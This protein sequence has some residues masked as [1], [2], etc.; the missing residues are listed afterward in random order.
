MK[1]F[2]LIPYCVLVINITYLRAQS[3]SSVRYDT[4]DG[5]PSST[6]YDVSQDKNGFIWFATENGL[7]RFDG[8][9]FK[10]FTTK[11]GLPDNSIL[12]VHGDNSGR[13]Y[14][15]PFTHSLYYYQDDKFFHVPIPEKYKVDL[16]TISLFLNK[17]DKIILS[18]ITD[19]YLLENGSFISFRDKYKIHPKNFSIRS[20][21][22]T[23]IIAASDDSLFFIPDS[24]KIRSVGGDNGKIVEVFDENAKEQQLIHKSKSVPGKYL[25]HNLLYIYL[26]NFINIYNTTTGNLIHKIKVDKFSNAFVDNENNLW[27]S[28]LGDGVYRF[29]SFSFR[30]I[31]FGGKREIFSLT[32]TDHQLIAGTDFSKM[33]SIPFKSAGDFY[34]IIDFSKLIATSGN[35]V[36]HLTKRNRI[37]ILHSRGNNL[38]IGADAFLLKKTGSSAPLFRNIYPV[39]DIDVTGK[40]MLVCTG[41]AVLL[42]EEQDMSVKDTLLRQRATCGIAYR[43]DYYIGTLGGLIK[44]D[45]ATKA[46]TELYSLFAPLK[47]RITALKKGINDDLWIATSGSGLVRFK[48]N[49]I[50]Q[51]LKEEDGLTSDICT[52][53]FIDSDLVWL[54]TNKGL[55][56]IETGKE[57]AV[58]TRFTS[59]NG[60]GA[61]FI[62]AVLVADSNVYVGT[63]TGLTIFSKN[64]LT[65]KSVCILHILQ[66][67]ENS[68]PLKTEN[69]YSFPYS[70]LNI[71]IDFTAIS[72][73]SA[74]DITYYYQLK[75][76]GNNWNTTTANFINF[77]TLQPGNYTLYL[78]AINKFG[79]ESDTKA[80]RIIIQPPWWQTWLFRITALVM[81]GSLVLVIYRYN[82]RNIKR[83]EEIKRE[84]ESRFS[85][86]EQKA[87]Q[88]QMNPHFIFNSLNSIQNFILDLD[89]EG[90]NSYLTSFASLIRQTLENSMQPLITV[91][92]ELK[93]LETYLGLEKLRFR[94]KFDYKILADEAIDQN[95]TL[96]PGM[97]L[98]PY[99]ENSIRHGIQH[100]KDNNGLISLTISKT[101]DNCILYA[102]SDN[103]VGRKKAEELK[104]SRH[105]A[106]QSR[107]ISINEKRIA[108]INNQFKTNIRVNTEDIVDENG[109]VTGTT[110]TVLI[111][112]ILK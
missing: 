48:D 55:N 87:L 85:A 83:K 45:A 102:I 100:R 32:K 20:V 49:K 73:K 33:Y 11:D 3:Y 79:V 99:I 31:S 36:T 38:Y 69:T 97:L 112:R 46:I 94:D 43:G 64:V 42:L 103:G 18:G 37:F 23:L 15:T 88:A 77:S 4:K 72:Y 17:K 40:K 30:D 110:V 51:T 28:T 59:A 105:I 111:P 81:L 66:V 109:M 75:G 54:G 5:L 106:Y 67:S 1:L 24:G 10:T 86:L 78:K 16:S 7:C 6:V 26:N 93:Y 2:I 65:E 44:I 104:S 96:L 92:S 84:F 82:I 98:Q 14:F 90:A 62:N 47:G 52:S 70:A 53:L 95:K 107:G 22:D 34:T 108:A 74:G 68:K 19:S 80:I 8:K 71:Q 9:N 25:S 76:L 29:P 35:T 61:D 101:S 91:A 60:L 39:K 50:I 21:Y 89:A 13:V 57:K 27:I 12:N 58:V 63:A 56:R 41:Q